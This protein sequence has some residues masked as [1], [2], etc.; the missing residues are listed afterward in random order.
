MQKNDLATVQIE[1]YNSDGMGVARVEG[2]AVFVRA[3]ARGDVCDVRITKVN[4]SAAWAKSERIESPSA[5]RIESRCP[6]FPKCG[7]CD[8][9]HITYSEELDAKLDRVQSALKRIGGV[10]PV[11]DGVI[12][13]DDTDWYRNK[14]AIPAATQDDRVVTG[15]YRL[16]SHDVVPVD[17][18]RIQSNE[19]N[20]A[21]HAVRQWA[22]ECKIPVFDEERMKGM[23]RRIL[24]RT[25]ADGK[26]QVTIVAAARRLPSTDRLIQLLLDK[27][28]GLSGLVL[29]VNKEKGNA[30][31]GKKEVTLWGSRLLEDTLC[32]MKFQLSPSSFYQINRAQ[33]ERLYERAVEYALGSG[34][35]GGDILD[36]YC[37][38]GTFTLCLAKYC[39]NVLGVEINEQAVID[40][41]A[42]AERNGITNARFI[43]ADS[44][45]IYDMPEIAGL[46]NPMVTVDPPRKGLDAET[47]KA[48][49][50]LNPA[51]IVYISCD[52]ATLARDV[53]VF[54]QNGYKAERFSVVDMFPR[55]SNVETVLLL[56]AEPAG[57]V[58]L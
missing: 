53:A 2:R 17:V 39:K 6:V 16:H 37:G 30:I 52:P 5:H 12:A 20:A 10:T 42:N 56:T 55:T 44:S 14:A 31:L 49:L 47:V 21:A 40:A 51:R 15:F 11:C 19:S 8:F 43:C 28:P 29:N 24:V 41:E 26:T 23:L 3:A 22:E 18:C 1:G 25:A 36:L 45:A 32:G 38:T 27:C 54:T 46:R 34:E 58:Q 13:A 48:I 35:G 57:A 4:S 7:G 33:A 9:Q 50:R